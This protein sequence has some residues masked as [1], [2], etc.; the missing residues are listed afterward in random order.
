M[1]EFP[2]LS[3]ELSCLPRMIA[4]LAGIPLGAFSGHRL[5]SAFNRIPDHWYWEDGEPPEEQ[6][7]RKELKLKD[8]PWKW[9]FSAFFLLTALRLCAGDWR[10]MLPAFAAV[11]ILTLL[12]LTDI[13]AMVLPD[14]LIALLAVTGFGFIPFHQGF[15][16]PA[17]GLAMGAGIMLLVYGT[18][19]LLAKTEVLGLGDVK[20]MGALGFILGPRGMIF[21]LAAGFL[22][23]GIYYG[24]LLLRRTIR[25]NDR[26]PL[27]PFLAGGAI[28]YL[29]LG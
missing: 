17:V 7:A 29:L 18:G 2:Y 8:Y 23:S 10:L 12:I 3:M 6:R 4:A 25:L 1:M 5:V 11:W 14:P 9:F 20:L 28:L 19:R 24:F 15:L 22:S 27:G 13:K 21:A 26:G 16:Y